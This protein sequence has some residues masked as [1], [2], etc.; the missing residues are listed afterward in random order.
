MTAPAEAERALVEDFPVAL[1]HKLQIG[2]AQCE[3]IFYFFK[4]Y[5]Y[6]IKSI[7]HV[8]FRPLK[9]NYNKSTV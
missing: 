4:T 1:H 8:N 7:Q 3:T 5:T 2:P 9:I 6:D